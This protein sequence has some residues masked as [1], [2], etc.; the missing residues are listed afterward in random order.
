MLDIL[1]CVMFPRPECQCLTQWE[2]EGQIAKWLQT[3]RSP[4]SANGQCPV[5][6]A[7]HYMPL[8][9]LNFSHNVNY[10]FGRYFQNSHLF[11]PAPPARR[12]F[13]QGCRRFFSDSLQLQAIA[14][15]PVSAEQ[16]AE[17]NNPNMWTMSCR[18]CTASDWAWVLHNTRT[19]HL[20]QQDLRKVYMT[21]TQEL[22]KHY[23]KP[24]GMFCMGK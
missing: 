23:L 15:K 2:G 21:Q 16:Q 12:C 17:T 18:C 4:L 20:S 10:R 14:A 7:V 19:D 22:G 3:F 5:S 13:S 8:P 1:H 24:A 9:Q 6:I 11:D